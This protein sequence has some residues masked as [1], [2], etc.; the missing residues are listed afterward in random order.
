MVMKFRMNKV[1]CL[2]AAI[3]LSLSLL[4]A[5][6]DKTSVSSTDFE[7][8]AKQ[9]GYIV[10][11]G[12]DYFSAYDYIKLATLA[13][14]S[15]KAFQI[16]FYELN[17][18]AVAKSFY[19]SNKSDF[20][21]MKG[22]DSLETIDSGSNYDIYKLEMYGKFMMIERVDNTVV[23]VHSTDSENKTAIESFMEELKY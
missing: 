15:D 2:L 23:Y 12:T 4:T 5:C 7:T 9:K 21:L 19:D 13:T 20:K 17:D 16:E 11:D 8:V 3:A 6:G 14:P 18:D 10:Q 1:I 22:P